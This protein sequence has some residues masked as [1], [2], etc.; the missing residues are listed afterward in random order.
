MHFIQ[1]KTK[2]CFYYLIENIHRKAFTALRTFERLFSI[3]ET[4]IVLFEITHLVEYL[5]TFI[6]PKLGAVLVL[7]GGL[8]SLAPLGA[9]PLIQLQG[10]D[11]LL[12]DVHPVPRHRNIA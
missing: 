9:V 12:E 7:D 11:V 4:L 8:G 1:K 5:V 2:I 10:P 6:A 3:V